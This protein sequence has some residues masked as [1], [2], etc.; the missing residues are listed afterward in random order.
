MEDLPVEE[1]QVRVRN[2]AAQ[3]AAEGAR[4]SA[5]I[6]HDPHSIDLFL[7]EGSVLPGD[8]QRDRAGVRCAKSSMQ[9]SPLAL[10]TRNS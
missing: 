1:V 7:T 10:V 3:L 6:A 4:P 8:E 5:A 9:R 2:E